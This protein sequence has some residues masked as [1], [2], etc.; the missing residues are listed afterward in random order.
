VTGGE[1]DG[2]VLEEQWRVVPGRPLRDAPSTELENAGDPGDSDMV[3]D[4]LGLAA[5]TAVQDAPVARPAT[6]QVDG[7]DLAERGDPIATRWRWAHTAIFRRHL[8]TGAVDATLEI[9]PQSW[10]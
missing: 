3:P 1:R 2:L 8:R 10:N 4:D 7:H 6:A 5:G 9:T